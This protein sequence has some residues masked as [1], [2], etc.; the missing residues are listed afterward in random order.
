LPQYGQYGTIKGMSLAIDPIEPDDVDE[1]EG[2]LSAPFN[3]E[4]VEDLLRLIDEQERL[5]RSNEQ[6]INSLQ[7]EIEID[8]KTGLL[9]SAGLKKA[10]E[11]LFSKDVD[12]AKPL[13]LVAVAIDLDKFKAVNDKFGHSEGD[14]VISYVGEALAGIRDELFAHGLMSI[15]FH[16][17][18]PGGDEYVLLFADRRTA[19]SNHKEK[20]KQSLDQFVASKIA[21]YLAGI[22]DGYGQTIDDDKDVVFGVS[23]G[24][25]SGLVKNVED[26]EQLIHLADKDA[27]KMKSGHKACQAIYLENKI[28]R[29]FLNEFFGA[30]IA[31]GVLLIDRQ[32]D[33]YS[34]EGVENFGHVIELIGNTEP[35]ILNFLFDSMYQ[36]NQ[37]SSQRPPMG[38]TT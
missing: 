37:R 11:R 28:F 7:R 6:L 23:S 8:S 19:F 22:Y 38:L 26:A 34:F 35:K 21:E 14:K 25:A 1:A 9:S 36:S 32:F 4:Y 12:D 31:D 15:D 10:L 13:N 30:E 27:F 5:L 18:R 2:K 33:M 29:N 20:R 24:I 16:A 3:T 17:A